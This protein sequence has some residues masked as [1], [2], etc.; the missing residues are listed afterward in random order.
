VRTEGDERT[1][2]NVG[3]RVVHNVKAQF[4]DLHMQEEPRKLVIG[5]ST[6]GVTAS[7]MHDVLPGGQYEDASS[8]RIV[9]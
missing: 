6:P 9:R 4:G 5:A 3:I 2:V 7:A 8:L 1:N